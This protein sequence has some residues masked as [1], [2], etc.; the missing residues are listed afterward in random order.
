MS[1][2]SIAILFGVGFFTWSLAIV[3]TFALLKRQRYVVSSL[4]FIEETAM[5]L[6]AVWLAK[7]YTTKGIES[8]PEIFACA[9]GGAVS[10]YI[11]M[12]LEDRRFTQGR[13]CSTDL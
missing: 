10:G 2:L 8:L 13:K 11:V 7:Q 9:L 5:L 4:I 1:L 12:L 6:I 3:R